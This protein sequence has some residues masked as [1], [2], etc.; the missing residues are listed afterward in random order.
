MWNED[1]KKHLL[2]VQMETDNPAILDDVAGSEMEQYPGQNKE[3][4]KRSPLSPVQEI[5]RN[6]TDGKTWQNR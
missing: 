1:R 2:N 6:N 4:R 3:E 5:I